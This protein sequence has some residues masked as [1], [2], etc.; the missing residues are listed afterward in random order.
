MRILLVLGALL[1]AAPAAAHQETVAY[2]RMVIRESGDVD[3]ALKIPVEDL[4]ETAGKSGH[5]Q[6]NAPEVRAAQE[7]FF[8]KFQPLIGMSSAGVPCPVERAGIEVPEDER[9]YGE[10]RFVFHCPPGVPVTLDYRVF[11]D[12]DPGHMGMLEVETLGGKGRAE[13]IVERPRWE[14]DPSAEGPPHVRPV[15]AGAAPPPAR[16]K[17]APAASPSV[18]LEPQRPVEPDERPRE[19]EAA[20]ASEVTRV[21]KPAKRRA[22]RDW[23]LVALVVACAMGGYFT[24]RATRR[25]PASASSGKAALKE[26]N[27]RQSAE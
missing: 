9:L 4:A 12:V 8:Q 5:A 23:L 13:L 18:A 20:A 24:L 14:V 25:R 21:E 10:M 19:P 22:N 17:P 1:L 2:S 7:L 16:S 11:F 27:P 3:Y 26:A 6:L 15:G